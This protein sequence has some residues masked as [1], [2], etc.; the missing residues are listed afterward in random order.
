MRIDRWTATGLLLFL[1]AAGCATTEFDRHFEARRYDAAARVFAGDSALQEHDRA[2]FRAGLAHAL[3]L[4]PVYSPELA[5]SLLE[6]LVVLHPRSAYRDGAE[7]ILAL[8]GE[9]ERLDAIAASREAELDKRGDEIDRLHKQIAWLE[10]RFEV[11]E[12]VID[13]LRQVIERLESE[14]RDK[15]G[16]IRALQDELDRLKEIDLKPPRSGEAD[17]TDG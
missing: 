2:L 8:L 10:A 6:R 13:A 3:P 1:G 16:R 5:R 14:A 11:Q 4:S 9:I 12:T 15:E 17:S 7:R